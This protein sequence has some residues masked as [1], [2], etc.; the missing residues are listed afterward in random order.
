[1]VYLKFK[2]LRKVDAVVTLEQGYKN[3]HKPKNAIGGSNGS[4]VVVKQPA[5][6]Y[7]YAEFP[8][9]KERA[10][11]IIDYVR[12]LSKRRN[13][14]Q[15]FVLELEC[16]ILANGGKILYDDENAT[17]HLEEFF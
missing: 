4:Y 9:G 1:M 15:K 8:D 12:T 6:L 11:E 17:M 3:G 14:T 13:I 16:K 2:G 7:L 10:C 5:R